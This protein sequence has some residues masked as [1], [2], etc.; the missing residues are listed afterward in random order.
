MTTTEKIKLIREI[1]EKHDIKAYDIGKNTEISLTSA[2]NVLE[3][4]GINPRT[5]TLNIIL[6][7]LEFTIAGTDSK[8]ELKQAYTNK[9][10]NNKTEEETEKFKQLKIDDKLNI[11]F[12]QLNQI[13]ETLAVLIYDVDD[14]VAAKKEINTK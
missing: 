12:N 1:A 7:Y 10:K 6:E 2:R 13:S 9:F 14:L 8:I 5:K 11:L 4:T 3:E